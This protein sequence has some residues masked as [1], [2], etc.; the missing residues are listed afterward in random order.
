[1][2][3]HEENCENESNIP[4]HDA[5]QQRPVFLHEIEAKIQRRVAEQLQKER[6]MQF[7]RYSQH[8]RHQDMFESSEAPAM[9]HYQMERRNPTPAVR[10]TVPAA[11]ATV[12]PVTEKLQ[13]ELEDI[14]QMMKALI[15]TTSTHR[16]CKTQIPFT[17]QLDVVPL[18]KGFILSQFTQYNDT[19]DPIKHLQG[20]L[21]KMTITSNNPDV[22]A[23][24]FS[25]SLTD[26][27]LDW[28]MVLPL[29]SIDSYQQTA[30][31]FIFKFGSSIQEHQD[32]RALMDIEQRRTN[33]LGVTIKDTMTSC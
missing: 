6:T 1:M 14:K 10:S 7:F 3:L 8:S 19:D 25:N 21:A 12:D 24:A 33:P 11:P 22:Y 18:P 29:K 28:Y 2:S 9:H 17:E 30:D 27:A 13:K 5:P 26:K 16:E 23:K 31:V 32:E 20:F 15:P 4:Q